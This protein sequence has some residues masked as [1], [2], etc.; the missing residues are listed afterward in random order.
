MS[1]DPMR[2]PASAVE[3]VHVLAIQGVR[4]T[5]LAR[6]SCQLWPGD[7][8]NVIRHQAEAEHLETEALAELR[9]GFQVE[10]PI[11]IGEEDIF[12]RLWRIASLRDV[13]RDS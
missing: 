5:A 11:V 2:L 1:S 9:E 13:V 6:L 4:P 7:Q 8:V 10:P 12:V 3:A